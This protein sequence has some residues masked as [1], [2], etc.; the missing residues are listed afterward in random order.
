MGLE[1]R[2]LQNTDAD[3]DLN[4][5]TDSHVH[6]LEDSILPKLIYKL[7]EIPMQILARIFVDTDKT[8]METHGT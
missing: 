5:C 7:N 1:C 3:K 6:G 8:Y 2:K 4:K